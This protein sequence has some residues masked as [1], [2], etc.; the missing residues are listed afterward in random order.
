MPL[1][2]RTISHSHSQSQLVLLNFYTLDVVV[3]GE[4]ALL[5][6]LGEDDDGEIGRRHEATSTIHGTCSHLTTDE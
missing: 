4:C 5:V 6:L 2:T 1:N 3:V